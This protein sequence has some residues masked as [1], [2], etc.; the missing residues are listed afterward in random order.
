MKQMRRVDTPAEVNEYYPKVLVKPDGYTRVDVSG[1]LPVSIDGF[2]LEPALDY[3]G[4]DKPFYVY[5]EKEGGVLFNMPPLGDDDDG[6]EILVTPFLTT[7]GSSMLGGDTWLNLPIPEPTLDSG[8]GSSSYEKDNL[9]LLYTG[10]SGM[11]D[12]PL[13]TAE[14]SIVD[15]GSGVVFRTDGVL[16]YGEAMGDYIWGLYTNNG[17]TPYSYAVIH[18]HQSMNSGGGGYS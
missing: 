10:R 1:E 18:G 16:T 3:S 15:P 8:I 17:V 4:N 2:I 6:G 11:D 12:F 9:Y 5:S 14:G 13:E 7:F